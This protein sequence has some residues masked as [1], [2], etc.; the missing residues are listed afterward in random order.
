MA[1]PFRTAA[2]GLIDRNRTIGFSFDGRRF[3]GHPGDTLASALLANGVHLV[4][5]SFKYHRPRGIMTAGSEEPNALV[6][7]GEG[8]AATDPNMRATTVELFDGLTAES[9]NRWPSLRHDVGVLN[10]ALS[11]FFPSG[12]YYKTFMWPASMWMTYEKVI[13][14]AAGLGR[15]PTAPD[16]DRYEQRVA[17]CDV[18]VVGAG[19]AG[20]AA[21]LAAA[22]SGAR[23]ILADEQPTLG[24]SLLDAGP[25]TAVD[26]GA[27]GAWAD[28]AAAELAEM[29]DATV[30]PRTTVFAY[31]HH[32]YLGLIER[33]TDHLAPADRPA[34][35]PR[36]R[37]WKVRARQV[38]LATGM[39]ERPLVFAENDRPGI[40]MAGAARRYV[41]RHGVVPGRRVAVFA[42]ND[43]AYLA[44]LDLAEAGTT[45]SAVIDIR[46]D[47]RGPLVE[48]AR[49]AG[50]D[51]LDGHAVV[52]T[53]GRGR[54]HTVRARPLTEAGD[55]VSGPETMLSVDSLLVSGGWNP[56]V[57]LFSQSRGKLRFDSDIASFVPDFA[58]QAERSAG[59]CNG[60][61][62]LAAVLAEGETAGRGAAEAAGFTPAQANGHYKAASDGFTP[63]RWLWLTPSTKPV[64]HGGKHFVDFQNDVTAADL[65]LALREGYTSVEH[66]KRYT[67]TGMGTDQGKT[68]NVNALG[69]VS[70]YRELPLE[71]LGVTTFRP[72]YTPITFGA[73]GGRDMEDFFDPIR[74]TPM[75]S[76]HE[77]AGAAFEDVGLWKRPW[78]Y[79]KAGETMHDAVQRESKAARESLGVLDATTLGRI[80]IQGP[81]SA[82]F[83]NRIYTNG[84][85]TLKPG[86]CR[87][88]L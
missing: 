83:L 39:I 22:R 78:Y 13:R 10:D 26:G 15:S 68:S 25:E 40:L 77:R 58:V 70:E 19:P 35:A 17:W 87:Y 21:A 52:G 57:H 31:Y 8:D 61:F 63:A 2:G 42:N 84:W 5:R 34:G 71:E 47:P 48:R 81:D 49:A 46:P 55:A 9:Q 45:V 37:L 64:G 60:T 23:V 73:W 53:E 28:A 6:Q 4:G 1:Q 86:F 72:P 33:V 27:P 51:I 54:V 32:N 59:A 79:P 76:W 11:P 67:T 3:E 75:H 16:P 82:E 66:V 24:G 65:H 29:P 38:V 43:G 44:A 12:F 74:K 30:L 69:I 36:Q 62:G 88:G 18:L 14:N 56:A 7:L 50:I 85:K 20:L 41:Q 80:D